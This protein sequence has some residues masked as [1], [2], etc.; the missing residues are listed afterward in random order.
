MQ[1]LDIIHTA[2]VGSITGFVVGTAM[3]VIGIVSLIL[4]KRGSRRKSRQ[5]AGRVVVSNT[6]WVGTARVVS[7]PAT[8]TVGRIYGRNTH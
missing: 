6:P 2:A 8:K 3:V 7:P 1:H 4:M 5:V